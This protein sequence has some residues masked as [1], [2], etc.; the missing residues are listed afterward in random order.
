MIRAL[1]GAT[2]ATVRDLAVAI[3]QTES[4]MSRRM[5]GTIPW[6]AHELVDIARYFDV[7]VGLLYRD[8]LESLKTRSEK[9]GSAAQRLRLASSRPKPD[10]RYRNRGAP[11]LNPVSL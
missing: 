5:K 3:G 8:P 1:L 2:G 10:A 4:A 9:S 7:P 11:L 6:R